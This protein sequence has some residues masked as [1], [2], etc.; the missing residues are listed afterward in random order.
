MPAAAQ[1]ASTCW[2]G[3]GREPD[4]CLGPR[5][6]TCLSHGHVLLTDVDTVRS[7]GGDQV[8]LVVEDEQRLVLGGRAAEGVGESDQ[9]LGA[10]R[11]LLPQLDYVCAPLEGSV[12]Q[13]TG[14]A[15]SRKAVANEVEARRL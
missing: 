14:L 4:Q 1:A 7:A 5:Q 13:R 12:E 11:G 6:P 9:L 15:A 3:M 10:A 2:G 8:R